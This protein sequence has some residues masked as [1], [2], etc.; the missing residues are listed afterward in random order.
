[1][2]ETNRIGADL[3]VLTGDLF[4]GDPSHVD[5]GVRRLAKLRARLGVYAVLGNHDTYTGSE[6]IAS[7][8]SRLAPGIRLLRDEWVALP[9]DRPLYLAGVDDPGG[10]WTARDLQLRSLELLAKTLPDDGPTVLLVHRPEAFRQ[11][12]RLGFPLV[13]AG[14]TH[15]GQISLPFPGGQLNPARILTPLVRGL[16]RRDDSILYVNRGVGMAGPR[17]RFNC[18]REIATVELG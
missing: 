9:V 4:D 14:H 12:S 1:V 17:I 15:G 16:Y 6:R 13:L 11:A 10:D 3:I 7:A 2:A 5:E 18:S 8:I